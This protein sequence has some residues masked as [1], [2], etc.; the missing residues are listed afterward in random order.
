MSW[1]EEEFSSLDLG[2]ARLNRRV[3]RLSER[4]ADKPTASLPG[5]CRG[6]AETQ[7]A[8]RL[9]AQEQV[10]W[11]D[12]LAPHW[13]C[14][15]TRMQADDVVL[16]IADT[17]VLDF[18][19]QQTAGLGPLSYEAQ[20][21][22]YLHV[23]YAVSAAR[24]PLGVLDA[25]MWARE[26]K[27]ANGKRPPTVKESRRWIEGYERLAEQAPG[28]AGTRLVY[29]ADR[30]ADMVALM[31]RAE[32][33]GHPL[34]YLIRAQHER[35]LANGG[36]LRATLAAAP[37]LGEVCFPL[38]AR[39]G[40]AAR[41]VCQQV[42]T[43]CVE[44]QGAGKRRLRVHAMLAREL[45]PPPGVEALHWCLL[46]NRPL[47]DLATAM[48]WIEQY[49]ARWEIEMFFNVL[50]NGCRVEALQ[51]SSLARLER[52]LALYLVVA[53]RIARLM[54]L[55][56]TCPDLE[57]ELFFAPEEWQA[58][59]VMMNKPLPNRPPGLNAVL[60]LVAQLG[61]FLARKGDGEPGAK[62]IWLGLQRITDFAEALRW[63]KGRQAGGGMAFKVPRSTLPPP[64]PPSLPRC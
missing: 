27:G 37:V 57:A 36:K 5:A 15:H 31:A 4:L 26:P 53:W 28:L 12:L 30:E 1:A 43:A 52:A 54:R 22:L 6:W 25:W 14:T 51:L 47:P 56:R 24:E 18:H 40:Q 48:Q 33:L 46:S 61:G 45:A 16:C 63:A 9:L 10:D 32:D 44:L 8:Y 55:G 19:G 13:A 11:R 2:D 50:K 39:T 60:R 20:R 21:G 58:A 42:Q 3:V 23:T 49:R 35:T 41:T 64:F 62:T 29:L 17:T 38:P 59:Y 7:G 34:D